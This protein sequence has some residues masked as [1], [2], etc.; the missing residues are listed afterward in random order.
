MINMSPVPGDR[1]VVIGAGMGGLAAAAVLTR[2][3]MDVTVLEAHVY[4][5]GSAGTFTH[6]GYRFDAGATLAGGFAPGGPMACLAEAAGI[7]AWPVRSADLAMRVLLPGSKEIYR[8]SDSRRW[9]ER[10]RVF[11]AQ[12]QA[13]WE[14]QERTADMLWTAT[15][16]GLPWPPQTGW[17]FARL[18]RRGVPPV[19]REASVHTPGW[20]LDAFRPLQHRIPRG[21]RLLKLFLDAQLLISAQ[22]T[23]EHAN[24]LYSAAALDLP[25]RGVGYV[26]GGMGALAETLVHAISSGGGQV[27]YRQVVE[28]ISPRLGGGFIVETSKGVKLD[29]R[30]VIANLTPGNL[31]QLLGEHAPARLLAGVPLA[32]HAWGAMMAYVGLDGTKLAGNHPLHQQVVLKTPLG[33][34]N[35]V[36]LS[37]SPDWDRGRA[38]QDHRALTI[39]THTRLAE[40]WDLYNSDH[41]AYEA[42]KEV[43]LERLLEAG[44]IAIPGLRRSA[45]LILPGTPITFEHYTRRMR[46]W[47]GGFPQTDLFRSRPARILPGLWMVGDSIFPGQSIA[48]VALGGLR[49]AE[50]V[51]REATMGQRRANTLHP[52]GN[53]RIPKPQPINVS[54]AVPVSSPPRIERR[55]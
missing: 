37:L 50:S 45:R 24:S 7:P 33:E 18:I 46:G 22:T 16:R 6:Q 13:F 49:I 5:G 36:F 9:E 40:W 27:I 55:R 35:S 26:E 38:P 19:L 4:P 48:A 51:L 34:G 23:S 15:I 21:D 10:A 44:E 54:P 29:A 31:G 14:W 53:A 25:R 32:H 30:T 39:S 3:G 41:H 1:V 52:A 8:W 47:V 2:S 42:R 43:Y 28:R 20:I 11:S 17:E 12:A